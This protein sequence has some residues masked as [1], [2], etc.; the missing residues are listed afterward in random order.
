MLGIIDEFLDTEDK[1]SVF[2]DAINM[3]ITRYFKELLLKG[4][5]LLNDNKILVEKLKIFK[6]YFPE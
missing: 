4:P 6:Q 3:F 5:Q 1:K 2:Q